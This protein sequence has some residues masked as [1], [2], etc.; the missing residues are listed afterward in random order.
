M[1]ERS[2]FLSNAGAKVRAGWQKRAEARIL[3]GSATVLQ[4]L[5]ARGL[6]K[7]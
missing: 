6:R 1:R 7:T 3:T 4:V 2:A 5:A